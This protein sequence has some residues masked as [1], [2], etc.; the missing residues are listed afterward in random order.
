MNKIILALLVSSFSTLSLAAPM[1]ATSYLKKPKLV[2]VLVVDQ[3]R[4]DMLT[5]HADRFLPAGTSKAPGGFRYLMNQGAWFPFAEYGGLQDMTCPGHATIF[6]GSHPASTGI[7]L[8][9]VFDPK[10]GKPVYCAF[11]EKD[12]LSPRRLRTTTVGDE[13]KAASPKSRVFAVAL[14]DRSSIMLGGHRADLAL[15]VDEES[16]RWATST[17][18]RGGELP[19]WAKAANAELAKGPP[20]TRKDPTPEAGIKDE[21]SVVDTALAALK[22]ERLGRGP[23]TD[24]LA[25]SLSYHDILGHQ[26]GPDSKEIADYTVAEDKLVAKFL[27][28][29]ARELG[30]LDDVVIAFTADHGIPPLA[31]DAKSWGLDAEMPDLR[32]MGKR[33]ASDLQKSFGTKK[34][35]LVGGYALHFYLNRSA[36]ADAKLEYEA[37][38]RELKRLLLAEPSIYTVVTRSEIEAGRYP[39]GVVGQQVR[40]AYDRTVSGDVV[41]VLKP[42]HYQKGAPVTHMTGWSYDRS[43]PLIFVGRSFK[44]GVYPG[45]MVVDLAPTVSF[46]LGVL[47]PAMNEGKVLGEALR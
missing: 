1:S 24:V 22:K 42:F 33:L 8:N 11:D 20:P 25:V 34:D 5:R 28:G 29:I 6:S 2:V 37:V 13:L 7:I 4:S 12:K 9:D 36:I 47:P 43:V 45:G 23:A 14:K 40:N 3:F 17:Y 35:L 10:V 18:Y 31:T 26:K 38:E 41:G 44:P 39:A 30:S 32:E 16:G 19:E 21:T 27:K 46:L 15:W